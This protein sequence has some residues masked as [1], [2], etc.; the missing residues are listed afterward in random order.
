M[1]ADHSNLGPGMQ[2]LFSVNTADSAKGTG[3]GGGVR[4]IQQRVCVMIVMLML[5]LVSFFKKMSNNFQKCV[6]LL[7]KW[8]PLP[9]WA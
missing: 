4:C 3:W 5:L 7:Y 1:C 6:A 2:H 8:L 9:K